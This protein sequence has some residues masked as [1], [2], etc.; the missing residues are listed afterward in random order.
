MNIKMN[1]GAWIGAAVGGGF[2]LLASVLLVLGNNSDA[3]QK[4]AEAFVPCLV[5]GALAGYALQVVIFPHTARRPAKR[6]PMP[7]EDED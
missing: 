2:P 4:A 6:R 7:F 5:V 3:A 1:A